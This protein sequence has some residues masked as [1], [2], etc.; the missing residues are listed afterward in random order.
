M[1]NTIEISDDD[2]VIT[3]V[4]FSQADDAPIDSPADHELIKKA[5]STTANTTSRLTSCASLLDR[6]YSAR[7]R[8][9]AAS[10]CP[11]VAYCVEKPR[12]K[13][14][15]HAGCAVRRTRFCD[16]ESVLTG[17]CSRS[18]ARA[19]TCA[20]GRRRKTAIGWST[21]ADELRQA[22]QVLCCCRKR[23]LVEGAGEAS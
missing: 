12:S 4:V 14:R 6:R 19:L 22:P 17:F 18:E 15:C 9:T 8:T 11:F 13:S 7:C 21:V 10:Q 16:E 23:E 2:A 5:P 20:S 1:L 3:H